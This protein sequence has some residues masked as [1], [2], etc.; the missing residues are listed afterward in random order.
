[1]NATP[2][3]SRSAAPIP[4]SN[5][6]DLKDEAFA[7][8]LVHVASLSNES[9]ER[10][11][12]IIGKAKAAGALV[13]ANPGPRQ[14]AARGRAFEDCLG[15]IDILSINLLGSGSHAAV[16]DRALRRRRSRRSKAPICR[17]LP[18]AGSMAAASA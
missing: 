1:M 5:P 9:A 6:Q 14:L 4:C 13:T 2:R 7:V 17:G 10:F 16:A 18:N 15:K 3:C 8:D 11:P 12:E